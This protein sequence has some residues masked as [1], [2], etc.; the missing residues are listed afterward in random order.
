[1]MVALGDIAERILRL[2]GITKER[3]QAITGKP[4]GC[5]KRQE[6]MNAWGYR[7]QQRMAVPLAWFINRWQ[8]VECSRAVYRFREAFR[9]FAI[10][11]RV[12]FTG[13]R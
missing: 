6:T 3:V 8:F 10:G 9:Y 2:F 11:F 12:L 1:M 13:R 7:V 4:C 5:K